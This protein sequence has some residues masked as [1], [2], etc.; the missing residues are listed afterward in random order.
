MR[1]VR[2]TTVLLVRREGLVALAADGQVGLGDT[3][4]KNTARKIRRLGDGKVLAGFAGS[5]ADAFSLFAR[6]ES[7]LEEF[8]GNLRRASVELARDWRTDRSLR[9]LEALLLVADHQDS[10]LISGQGDVIEPDDGVMGIGSGG[11][12]A[13]AAARAMFRFT[14]K[15]ADEIARE[16]LQI[17]SEI[18]VHTNSHI[19]LETL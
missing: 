19:L 15:P 8:R 17:A 3:V 1:T 6:F 14:E 7:K 16:A 18:C 10:F 12:Y 2:G 9:H 5:T 11:A 4:I 13:L